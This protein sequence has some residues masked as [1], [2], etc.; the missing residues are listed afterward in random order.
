LQ[1][2]LMIGQPRD[3]YEQEADRVVDAALRMP[4]P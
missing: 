2:K 3:K 4:E 1:A